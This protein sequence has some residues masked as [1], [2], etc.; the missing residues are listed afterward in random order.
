MTQPDYVP[1]AESEEVRKFWVQPASPEAGVVKASQLSLPDQHRGDRRG[2]P[3][4]DMG[5]A[6]KLG[7]RLKGTLELS[8]HEHEEDAIAAVVALAMKRASLFGRAPVSTDLEVS[9]SLLGYR[10]GVSLEIKAK[11]AKLT[12]GVSHDYQRLRTLVDSVIEESLRLP[13]DKAKA[14]AAS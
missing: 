8:P 9:A 3:G 1:I 12:F 2:S 10:G 4:P 11:T 5:Y 14:L 6:L 7:Q 13:L